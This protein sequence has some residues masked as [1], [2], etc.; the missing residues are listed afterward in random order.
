M[1]F[2][3]F[4]SWQAA[5]DLL[6]ELLT[7]FVKV[8]LLVTVVGTIVAVVL[9]LSL[10][11]ITQV[12]PSVIARPVRWVMDV[13]RMTPL[14]VQLVFASFLVPVDWNLL[15]VGTVVIGVHYS[16]YMAESFIA[17]IGSVDRGQWEASRA[18]SLPQAR[19]WR[20]IVLPQAMRATLPSLGNWTI[21]MF[22]DT[23]YLFAISVL[24][25]VTVAQQA[26][27]NTFRYNE[28]F[29]I[30]GL[31]FLVASLVTALAVRRL[32]KAL[33]Y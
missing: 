23:P 18:L 7:A 8:T 25:M 20:A 13:I 12:T 11:L 16:T 28:A 27:N 24:E 3:Q 21:S 33:V 31:I 5:A 32:E 1:T 26:G 17:G 6:P 30:A 2:D 19:T 4:W 9:G 10:A 14:I 15:W 29:T 22:K